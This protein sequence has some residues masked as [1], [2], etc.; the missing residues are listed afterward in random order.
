MGTPE[1]S[2]PPLDKIRQDPSFEVMAVI[3]QPDKPFG[4]NQT[5][6]PSPVKLYS[7][8]NNLSIIQPPIIRNN[9][10]T[11]ALIKAL[12]PDFIITAAYGQIIP[13]EI[14]NIPKYFCINIHASLLPKYRGASPI[15]ECLLHGDEETG[16][17]FIKMDRNMDTG[18]ILLTQ[19]VKIEPEDEYNSL[20]NK[21]CHIA[22]SLITYLIKDIVCGMINSIP[23]DSKKASYCKKI[24]KTQG[25]LDP[26]KMTAKDISNRVRAFNPWPSTYIYVRGKRLKIL[27]ITVLSEAGGKNI[28]PGKFTIS[29]NNT[30]SLGTKEGLISLDTIQLEGKNPTS[31]QD[32]MRGNANLFINKDTNEK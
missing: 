4:R 6:T 32:F 19:R 17:T 21:L 30:V 16:I 26:Q 29:S 7:I 13:E 12:K 31:I 18:D 10:E 14:L 11:L 24:E 15:E 5:L 9:K 22:S 23:Q 27:K 20:R 1:F 2:V 28:T 8:K 3:T 25:L